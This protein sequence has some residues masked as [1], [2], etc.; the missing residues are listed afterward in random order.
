MPILSEIPIIGAWRRLGGP[1]PRKC[2]AEFRSRAFF[3]DGDNDEAVAINIEKNS[4]YDF[5]DGCGGGVLKLVQ[6]VFGCGQHEALDWLRDE[7]GLED[8][9]TQAT[10]EEKRELR[11]AQAEAERFEADL[12]PAYREFLRELEARR[13]ELIRLLR[14]ADDADL[15]MELAF[16]YSRIET[17]RDAIGSD[18][19]DDA[20]E[21][22]LAIVRLLE[23][24]QRK[25]SE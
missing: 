13:D 9:R 3:R 6:L 21:T 11:L 18:A 7:F 4:Y 22:A 8:T 14:F 20:I 12:Q 25:E 5:R 17:M 23:L 16:V 10:P 19:E 15:E 2:G 24:A 1:E